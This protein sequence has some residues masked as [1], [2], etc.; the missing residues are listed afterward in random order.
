MS[1]KKVRMVSSHFPRHII[2]AAILALSVGI[3]AGCSQPAAEAP[4]NPVVSHATSP[5]AQQALQSRANAMREMGK[6]RTELMRRGK[7]G[8]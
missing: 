6:K 1:R 2:M 5:E 8:Q 3:V 7:A 4:K